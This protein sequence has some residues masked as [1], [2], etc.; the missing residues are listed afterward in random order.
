MSDSFYDEILL[1]L[2]KP[3][4]KDKFELCSNSLLRKHFQTLVPIRG[5]TDSG[6]DGA[7]AASGPFLVATT[8][9]NVIR[10]LRNSL[11]S[12]LK[13][14]G[15][16]R[17]VVVA[18]SQEL[19]QRRRRNLQKAASD[20][21]FSLLH[22]YPQAAM[23]ELLYYEPR[24]CKVLLGLTG[25]PSA[26]TLVPQSDRP[27]MDHA[28]VGR[29]EDIK[30]LKDTRGDRLLV[31]Q[32]GS[33]KT[34]VLRHLA[35]QGWGLFLVDDDREAIANAI[36]K[37]QPR[38]IIIDD[39][40]V[41][42]DAVAKL[43]QLRREIAA[44]FDIVVTS[45]EG[46]KDQVAEALTLPTNQIHALPLLTRDEI[47]QVIRHAG[48]GGPVELV[49]EIVDQAEGRPG[50]AVTLSYLS[51]SGDVREVLYGNA[52]GRSLLPAFKRLVGNHVAEILASFALGGDS[53]MTMESVSR[54]LRIPL[55]E[56]RSALVKL[57]AGGII[58][59]RYDAR[60]AVWPRSLRYVLVRDTF[61]GRS[62]DL[63]QDKLVAQVDSKTDLAE[64]LIGAIS[65][66]AEVPGIIQLLE[67]IGSPTIWQ[68]YAG[69]GEA[70]A[71]FVLSQHPEL[72]KDVGRNTLELSPK[73]T[74]PFLLKAAV[75][76]QRPIGN[77][78]NHPLRWIHDWIENAEPNNNTAIERRSIVI[79]SVKQ[80]LKTGGDEL[81]GLK[82]L[83]VALSPAFE[84]GNLDPGSGMKFHLRYGLLTNHELLQFVELWKETSTI[85][86]TIESNDWRDLL[87]AVHRWIYPEMGRNTDI[88]ESTREIMRTIAIQMVT[89]IL[90]TRKDRP[91][92]HKWARGLPKHLGITIDNALD[93]EFETLFPQFDYQD[94]EAQEENQQKAV[95]ALVQ[96]W[97][98]LSAAEVASKLF[99]LETEASAAAEHLWPRWSPRACQLLAGLVS[100]PNQWLICFME[101]KL[102]PDLCTPFLNRVVRDK[103][104]GWEE[105]VGRC[106]ESDIYESVAVNVL[107]TTPDLPQVLIKR[108]LQSSSKFPETIH[109]SCLRN[110]VPDET[111]KALL[112]HL[113]PLVSAQSAMGIWWAEPRGKIKP[114]VARE[115]KAAILR[116][117]GQQFYLSE[118]LQSDKSLAFE[119]LQTRL[120][121]D[122]PYFDYYTIQEIRAAVPV[123]DPDQRISVLSRL[124]NDGRLNA[125]LL[126]LLCSNDLKVCEEV[127]KST[128]FGE[129]RLNAVLEGHPSEDWITRAL[130]ALSS[131]YSEQEI[132]D[133]S[134]KHDSSWAGEVSDMWQGWINDFEPLLAHDD[135]RIRSVAQVAL[136]KLKSQQADARKS[137]R[138]AAIYAR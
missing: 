31:G 109:V 20:L 57:A 48:L 12:Y 34:C 120:N 32:P 129:E 17:T 79:H 123:L 70:E 134:V 37:Q 19:T 14:D 4:D 55:A 92:F 127:L 80:W 49:R 47:I 1:A 29:D 44:D 118:I 75:G 24:W 108:L 130:L 86:S 87:N 117:H 43:K 58:R 93:R 104:P 26:L 59:Q 99:R 115:W 82:A 62:C 5:G 13:S 23:A 3:L 112:T 61:F 67:S 81:V 60:L 101:T 124:S 137:E 126:P 21:G 64:T 7:T 63:P 71:D 39:A 68:R 9:M 15:K 131:G 22:I 125:D 50:L 8:D 38:V 2:A 116:A 33:G 18:T 83:S 107:L 97:C 42:L 100:E 94:W 72:I 103:R 6:M 25:R 10:N 110:E 40:H 114:V 41:R 121:E 96:N 30:R 28:P 84:R 27:L 76:D 56:L 16:R 105:S 133:A 88:P 65:R 46:D 45:W 69:L 78:T 85:L 89:D 119:W 111:L 52:L 51:L 73:R 122:P 35:L 11:K 53:G 136:N 66:G 91:S 77:A 102:R 90:S 36:R 98:V 135:E 132:V 128:R 74:L 138:L 95:V 113:H 106:F 54:A